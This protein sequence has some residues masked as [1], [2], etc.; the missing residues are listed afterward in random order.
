MIWD[1]LKTFAKVVFWVCIVSGV[2]AIPIAYFELRKASL[3]QKIDRHKVL[4]LERETERDDEHLQAVPE[5]VLDNPNALH[6]QK[7][8]I[9][10]PNYATSDRS[11]EHFTQLLRYLNYFCSEPS[12]GC[13]HRLDPEEYQQSTY[14]IAFAEGEPLGELFT[15]TKRSPTR[16]E[17]I[18]E[19]KC[20]D[21]K[22]T[23]LVVMH[24]GVAA[25]NGAVLVLETLR[26][27]SNGKGEDLPPDEAPSFRPREIAVAGF[28]FYGAEYLETI[29]PT[30][31]VEAEKLDD[32]DGFVMVHLLE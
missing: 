12:A 10:I 3:E 25:S 14:R 29:T 32:D 23:R 27:R 6:H 13:F 16:I 9:L 28:L 21:I 2:F 22:T 24:L 7:S 4:W 26:R 5:A 8:S 20:V 30:P 17:A 18:W 11:A 31:Q 15:I 1:T 19:S